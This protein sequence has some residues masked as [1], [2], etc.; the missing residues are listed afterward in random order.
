MGK[1]HC[2]KCQTVAYFL[3]WKRIFS[4]GWSNC[5]PCNNHPFLLEETFPG[6]FISKGGD[7]ITRFG[8]PADFF[9]GGFEGT[10]L[11]KRPSNS[12]GFTIS[13]RH[14]IENISAAMLVK[15]LEIWSRDTEAGLLYWERGRSHWKTFKII[16][17]SCVACCFGTEWK[18]FNTNKILTYSQQSHKIWRS[19]DHFCK[20]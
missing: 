11:L 17:P 3:N 10:C 18:G 4:R 16:S 13:T 15:V 1:N 9:Y 12:A 2:C 6:K 7:V 5:P 20:S 19:F 14:E 8:T